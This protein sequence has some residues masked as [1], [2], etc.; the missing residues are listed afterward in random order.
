M[1]SPC[2]IMSPSYHNKFDNHTVVAETG[3]QKENSGVGKNANANNYDLSPSANEIMKGPLTL[4]SSSHGP[5][6]V[7][8]SIFRTSVDHF[9]LVYPDTRW[10]I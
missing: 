5:Q 4:L 7:I 9:A 6:R 2:L 8:L 3:G 1:S 10:V